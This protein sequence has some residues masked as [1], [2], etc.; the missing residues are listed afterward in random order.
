MSGKEFPNN[1]EAVAQCPSE[2]FQECTY[3]EF[4]EWRLCAWDIPASVNC[5]IRAERKDTGEITE[6][7]YQKP[8]AA[9]KRMLRYLQ[10]GEH[11]LTI[12]SQDAIHLLKTEEDTDDTETD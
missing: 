12:C 3:E 11:E 4:I 9:K 10:D 1:W 5:I 8:W 6:H 2:F 7:V